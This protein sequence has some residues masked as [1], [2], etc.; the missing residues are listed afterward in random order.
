MMRRKFILLLIISLVLLS[1]CDQDILQP[2]TQINPKKIELPYYGAFIISDGNTVSELYE[3][4]G[5]PQSYKLYSPDVP[6]FKTSEEITILIWHPMINLDYFMFIQLEPYKDLVSFR[7]SPFNEEVLQLIPSNGLDDG[8]YCMAQ[9]G[10]LASPIDVPYW[11]F[12][13]G[14]SISQTSQDQEQITQEISK[15]NESSDLLVDSDNTV[16][17][18][19]Y[20]SLYGKSPIEISQNDVVIIFDGWMAKEKELV[21]DHILNV[22]IEVTLD[23]ERINFD[24]ISEI[25]PDYDNN[26]NIEGYDVYFEKYIGALP[27]GTHKVEAEIKWDQ[28]IFDGWDYYGPGTSKEIIVGYC[29]I[30]VN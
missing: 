15:D 14:D 30:I 21:I 3:F 16:R 9:G 6:I 12:G 25:V 24:Y 17:V 29:E 5:E 19:D 26:N 20:C 23:G 22:D 13:I 28:K 27:S 18:M 4:R 8:F 11:C 2:K 10:P 1:S 7:I